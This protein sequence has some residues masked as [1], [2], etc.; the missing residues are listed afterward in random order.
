[1]KKW[2]DSAVMMDNKT[3]VI[4]LK[5]HFCVQN[6]YNTYRKSKT[7]ILWMV[8]IF[9]FDKPY[10]LDDAAIG[11]IACTSVLPAAMSTPESL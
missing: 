6:M 10:L 9:S 1:M 5:H 8:W 7:Q 2:Y 4:N 11:L 3:L